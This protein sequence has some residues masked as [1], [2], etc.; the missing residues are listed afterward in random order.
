MQIVGLATLTSAGSGQLGFLSNPKYFSQL[1][2]S[3]ASAFIVSP[4]IGSQLDRPCLLTD[5]PYLAYAHASQLFA[6]LMSEAAGDEVS[7]GIH[8]TAVVSA[9]A[10]IGDGVRIEA[11]AVVESGAVIGS[12]CA[13][14][15][16]VSIGRGVVMGDDCRLYP[17]V[18]LYKAVQLGERVTIH[19]GTVIGADGFGFAFDGQKSVK[20]AQLGSVQIGSDVEIGA[21]TTIDRGALD[22]TRIGNGVKIDNQ[23]QIGHNCTVG[24]HTVICG[25]TAL[26][27]STHVGRYCLI[28]GGVGI[29]GHLTIGDR[30]N[31]SAMSMVSKSIDKPGVY[32]SGSLVQESTQWRRNAVALTKL[33]GLS[34]TVRQIEKRLAE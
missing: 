3:A 8:P 16:G 13:I 20:I 11:H 23:V 24:D 17:N 33:A 30:V 10:I 25:C 15:A 32:A 29:T 2:D 22:D 19:S 12:R 4:E 26:A 7:T 6:R 28:G 1:A 21:G 5:S 27:G 34:R 31:I 9:E 14:G 18:V